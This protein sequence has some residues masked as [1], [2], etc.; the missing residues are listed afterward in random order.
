M[1]GCKCIEGI[2]KY[3]PL[4]HTLIEIVV[5]CYYYHAESLAV[6]VVH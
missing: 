4:Q 5:A 1:C 3:G 6:K 2:L